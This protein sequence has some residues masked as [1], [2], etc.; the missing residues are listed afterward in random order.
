[1]IEVFDIEQG[2]DE[3][4]NLH[5]GI[6]TASRFSDVLANGERKTRTKYLRQKAGEILTGE[7][8]KTYSNRHMDRGNE[9]EDEARSAYAF[10]RGADLHYVGFIRNGRAGCS[11]DSL[12]GEDGMLEIKTCLPDIL[13]ANIES[14]QFPAEHVAQC[15]GGLLVAERKWIDIAMYWPGM[16]LFIKRAYRNEVDIRKLEIALEAFNADLDKLIDRIRA[17]ETEKPLIEQLRESAMS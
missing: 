16:P 14:G 15:Q 8:M 5:I 9:M 12:I 6:P 13:I 3:W 2:S 17:Y 11:P 7:P 10:L 4:R 1:M